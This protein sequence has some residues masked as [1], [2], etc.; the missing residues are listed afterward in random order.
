MK[1]IVWDVDDVLNSLIREWFEGFWLPEHGECSLTYNEIVE[2]PPHQVLNISREDYLK[3]I[4][5]FRASA[6]ATLQLS[7]A[8]LEWFEAHG[9]KARHAVLTAVPLRAAGIWADWVMR[10]LGRWVR[11]FNFVPSPRDQELLPAYDQTKGEF[12]EWWRAA[13][14]V[15]DDNV[16]TI[17]AARAL[18]L[19]TVLV[20]QPWNH[21]PGSIDD[22]L[23]AL[24]RLTE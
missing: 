9:D 5:E 21:A 16:A 2:N 18:G 4:D 8:V 3:S 17:D 12:L 23:T 24:T 7:P 11:T 22:A 19:G 20:P 15:V 1:T 6:G 14:I 13:D 10:H